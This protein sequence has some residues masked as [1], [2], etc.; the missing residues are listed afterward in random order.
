M[1]RMQRARQNRPFSAHLVPVFALAGA[2]AS[3]WIAADRA[4]AQTKTYD[5]RGPTD[6]SGGARYEITNPS[7]ADELNRQLTPII[8]AYQVCDLLLKKKKG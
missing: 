4:Q 3:G 1:R 7:L 2:L 8:G 5:V 6:N